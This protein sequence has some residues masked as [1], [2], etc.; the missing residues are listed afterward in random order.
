[1]HEVRPG[2]RPSL[3]TDGRWAVLKA[4]YCSYL[5]CKKCAG[6]EGPTGPPA[7]TIEGLARMIISPHCIAEGVK[8]L[9]CGYNIVR[10]EQIHH[11]TRGGC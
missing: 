2:A 3:A 6:R 9:Y 10:L 11:N 1:M 7:D 4:F 5:G 8:N